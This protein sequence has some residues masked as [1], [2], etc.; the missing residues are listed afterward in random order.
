MDGCG[1]GAAPDAAEFGDTDHPN[2]LGHIAQAVGLSLP[3]L[4]GLGLGRIV[5]LGPLPNPP[6]HA[7]EG[8]Y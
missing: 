8:I 7:G 1:V 6:P 4:R 5:D 2:T 3:T